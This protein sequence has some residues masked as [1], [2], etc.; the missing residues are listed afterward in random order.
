MIAS[1]TYRNFVQAHDNWNTYHGKSTGMY[2]CPEYDEFLGFKVRSARWAIQ[3]E[4]VAVPEEAAAKINMLC[5][6]YW[7]TLL[8]AYYIKK[9]FESG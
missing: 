7:Q 9:G 1:V 6:P 2:A 5:G 4:T 3:D 8:T